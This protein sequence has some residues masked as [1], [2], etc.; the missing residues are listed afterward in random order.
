MDNNANDTFMVVK[1]EAGLQY[2]EDQLPNIEYNAFLEGREDKRG[3]TLVPL[4]FE[5][6]KS[7]S[8]WEKRGLVCIT[9]KEFDGQALELIRKHVKN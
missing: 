5:K 4:S 3:N 7:G 9:N 6:D 2:L 1:N 8:N